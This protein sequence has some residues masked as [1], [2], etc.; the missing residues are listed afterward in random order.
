MQW[1]RNDNNGRSCRQSH[2][3]CARTGIAHPVPGVEAGAAKGAEDT[4]AASQPTPAVKTA[5]VVL[6]QEQYQSR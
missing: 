6:E 5:I 1:L 2:E 3:R 4:M